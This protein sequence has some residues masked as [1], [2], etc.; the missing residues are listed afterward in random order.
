MKA[1]QH[2]A[3]HQP[4]VNPAP[5]HPPLQGGCLVIRTPKCTRNSVV[6]AGQHT[7][8]HQPWVNPAP[9]HPPLQGGCLAIRT[10]KCTVL[11]RQASTQPH[12]NPEWTQLPAI[13]LSKVDA[14]PLG[15]PSVQ[16]CEDRPAHINP[17]WTQLPAILLSK[18]GP[19]RWPSGEASTSRAEDPGFKTCQD[20]F[21]V[22]SYQWLKNWH[23]SGY[24][25]R[26]LAL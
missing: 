16:C 2:T 9:C 23:S 26:H 19:P 22:K 18:V 7:A 8:T 15:H 3:T 14:S 25:A 6:K 1:G 11:W 10:P 13:L 5:C 17:E 20:F 21:G 24:P 4:W 12:V